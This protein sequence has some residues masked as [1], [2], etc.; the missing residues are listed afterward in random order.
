M[1]TVDYLSAA[2]LK[3]VAKGGTINEDVLQKIF[4]LTPTE[5]PF[6]EIVGTSSHSNPT[7][8]WVIDALGAPNLSNA[9][10][11]GADASTYNNAPP[12]KRVA[13]QSQQSTKVIAVTTRAQASDT[14][15]GNELARQIVARQHELKRDIEAIALTGQASVVDDGDS[16]PGKSGGLASFIETNTSFGA[17]ATVGGYSVSTGLTVAPVYGVARAASE[18]T[19]RSLITGAWTEGGNPTTLMSTPAVIAG[20]S[21]YLLTSTAKVATLMSDAGQGKEQMVAKGAVS[22]YVSDFGVTVSFIPN[23]IQQTTAS[24]KANLY[25]IDPALIEIS[26]LTPIMVEPL[27]KTGTADKRQMLADWSLKVLNEK[28]LALYADIN[29]ATDWVA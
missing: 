13:N 27:A 14:I 1:A 19:L 7:C 6:T 21:Q 25:V 17:N 8:E 28:G 16:V 3:A 10:V 4:D 9:Q 20:F 24:N 15:G 2:D 5:L 22:V 29:S 23:R 12:A 26:Y 18:D 11:D